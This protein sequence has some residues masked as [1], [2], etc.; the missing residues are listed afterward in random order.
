MEDPLLSVIKRN[1]KVAIADWK[2]NENQFDGSLP[3]EHFPKLL[4]QT[5]EPFARTFG[6]DLRRSLADCSVVPPNMDKLNKRFLAV[7]HR[8]LAQQHL[9]QM[10]AAK[11]AKKEAKKGTKKR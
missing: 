3:K 8:L 5:I 1:W 10:K 9:D 7:K 4:A 2:Q 6:A 11:Q